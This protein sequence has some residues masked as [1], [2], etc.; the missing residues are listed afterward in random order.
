MKHIFIRHPPL[1]GMQGICYGT[2]DIKVSQDMILQHAKTLK[3]QLPTDF[4]M[5]SSPLQRCY[6]LARSMNSNLAQDQRLIEMHFGHWQGQAW[7]AID[8][9]QLDDWAKDVAHYR[10]P[11]GESFTD[12]IARLSRFLD[13]LDTP[14]ILITHAGVI[15]AAHFLLGGLG[16]ADAAVIDVPYV[17]PIYLG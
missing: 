13:T 4:P 9:G 14:H 5:I 7:S 10:A 6:D 3:Q 2:L 1:T 15:R 12:V 11:N 16:M 17:T 8:R